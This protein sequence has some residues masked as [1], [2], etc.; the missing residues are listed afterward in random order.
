M[1]WLLQKHESNIIQ[2]I[3]AKPDKTDGIE[4]ISSYIDDNVYFSRDYG[5]I[6]AKWGIMCLRMDT[7]WIEQRSITG[8]CRRYRSSQSHQYAT[9]ESGGYIYRTWWCIFR[10]NLN[11]PQEIYDLKI[12]PIHPYVIGTAAKDHTIRLWT[13]DPRSSAQ[14]TLAILGGEG[15]HREGVLT[16]VDHGL[17]F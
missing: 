17:S 7:R 5:L 4:L 14:P 1:Y 13:L 9:A 15:G 3:I 8:C 12:S 16:M 11:W 2:A 6:E 10:D